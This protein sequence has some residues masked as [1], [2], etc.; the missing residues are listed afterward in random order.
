MRGVRFFGNPD[1][2]LDWLQNEGWT[3][4]KDGG[5][6]SRVLICTFDNQ[7]KDPL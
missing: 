3:I 2:D 7:A 5:G 4:L 1:L 6:G